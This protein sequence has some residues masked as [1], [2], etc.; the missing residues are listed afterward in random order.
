VSKNLNSEDHSDRTFLSFLRRLW[1]VLSSLWCIFKWN[2][3]EKN[4]G[5]DLIL[6]IGKWLDGCVLLMNFT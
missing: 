1:E 3:Q 5:P 2:K 4:V 6:S